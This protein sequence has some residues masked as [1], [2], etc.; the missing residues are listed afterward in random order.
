MAV[1]RKVQTIETS[2][3]A[4]TTLARMGRT[5]QAA[6][7]TFTLRQWA[8]RLATRA[9]PKD[10]RGQLAQLYRGVI[11][12]WRYVL[13]D[14]EWIHGTPS[15]LLG[16]V[17]GAD[18][19]K[20]ETCP[21]PTRCDVE[22]TCWRER[23]WGDCDD[24][25]T[26]VA[27]GVIALGM[28]PF[29]RVSRG[30]D[31]QA[32]VSVATT[33]PRGELVQLDP[34]GH[35]AHEFGWAQSGPGIDVQ[36]LSLDGMPVE[37]GAFGATM[38]PAPAYSQAPQFYPPSMIESMQWSAVPMGFG[39]SMSNDATYLGV[40][41]MT[42]RRAALTP[43]QARVRR[44]FVAVAPNDP[45]GAR[46][47][48]IPGWHA[49]SMLRGTVIDGCPA[50]D[51]FGAEYVYSHPNDL[52]IPRRSQ[53]AN[54]AQYGFGATRAEKKARR[55]A[56]RRRVAKKIGRFF[57]K[58]GKGIRKVVGKLLGSKLVQT[59]VAGIVQAFGV[60]MAA[61]KAILRVA[62]TFVG[63]GGFIKLF[64]QL[65]KNPKAALK[66]LAKTVSAAGRS[67]LLK[68]LP[69]F[70]GPGQN[71][72]L[73][74][75]INQPGSRAPFYAS[76]VEGIVGL[77]GA[78]GD[79]GE[80]GASISTSPLPGYFYRVKQGDN[81]SDVA[82]AAYGKA[83]PGS[84]WIAASEANQ[85]AT[86]ASKSDYEKKYIGARTVRFTNAFDGQ[87]PGGP[88]HEYP[89]I[90]IPPASRVEPSVV[91]N[92]PDDGDGG[93]EP[94][95]QTDPSPGPVP[96][97]P[98]PDVSPD[99]MV[100]G[101]DE[102]DVPLPPTPVDVIPIIPSET[103][104]SEGPRGMPILSPPQNPFPYDVPGSAAEAIPPGQPI[105]QGKDPYA[106]MT[107][108]QAHEAAHQAYTPPSQPYNPNRH[109]AFIVPSGPPRGQQGAEGGE[110]DA[111][112]FLPLLFLLF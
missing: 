20:S 104:P 87:I 47:L 108:E 13:E 67:D 34:V 51:Q 68:S 10:Y 105:Q 31:G 18:Y 83:L 17:L 81:L 94:D 50:V 6:A 112:M 42:P 49:R 57:V 111:L 90:W 95:D 38:Y 7:D 106:P 82:K 52:W 59:I 21:D 4:T 15:S 43:Y 26:L 19:N 86:R 101:D 103:I 76:P 80:G 36:Y 58:V 44:H 16:V 71:E 54:V 98:V 46:V 24:V 12:R 22:A 93:G 60:P 55:K 48:A 39:A 29:W 63:E 78:F 70:K 14:G 5:A 97:P 40:L 32:H 61:T 88:G 37:S 25:A 110:G 66:L 23:G 69:G 9:G 73:V 28:R 89:V 53:A 2:T 92:I 8:A 100:P 1:A 107:P 62:A 72:T 85:F 102:Q 45:R 77:D 91:P 33:T 64:Q 27:A 79:A 11:D 84:S 3:P 56:R 41:A 65:R 75:E 99:E 30:P 74:Y 96:V 109:P 35:P